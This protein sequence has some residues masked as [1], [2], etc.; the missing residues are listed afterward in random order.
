MECH[1]SQMFGLD[2]HVLVRKCMYGLADLIA[3]CDRIGNPGDLTDATCSL[4]VAPRATMDMTL[5][6]DILPALN[7]QVGEA[8]AQLGVDRTTL[9][10]VLNG[11]AAISP[12]MALRIERWLGR[13]QG[14]VRQ[15]C[16]WH[17]RLLMTSGKL[18]S[19]PR[20]QSRYRASRR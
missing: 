4:P 11:R 5:R 3:Q 10:K 7:L 17:S 19:L 1:Q 6:D 16:G 12:A 14:G 15:K 18:G 8:A 2:T 20:R 13:D 9:S